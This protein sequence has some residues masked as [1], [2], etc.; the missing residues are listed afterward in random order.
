MLTRDEQARVLTEVRRILAAERK[1]RAAVRAHR[2]HPSTVRPAIERHLARLADL[3]K[4][5]G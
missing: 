3:L 2:V 5:L 4:E 1:L